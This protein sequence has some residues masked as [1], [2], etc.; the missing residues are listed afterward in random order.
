MAV[1]TAH[2]HAQHPWD[3]LQLRP[4]PSPQARACAPLASRYRR[5]I[6]ISRGYPRADRLFYRYRHGPVHH[7]SRDLAIDPHTRH[8]RRRGKGLCIARVLLDRGVPLVHLIDRANQPGRGVFVVGGWDPSA[9]Y[10]EGE[11]AGR[12]RWVRLRSQAATGGRSIRRPPALRPLVV[13]PARDTK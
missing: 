7:F 5:P 4:L 6:A 2:R 12:T 13:S 8:R 10:C 9:P 11:S 3:G 1:C